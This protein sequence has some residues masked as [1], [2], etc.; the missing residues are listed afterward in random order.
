[1]NTTKPNHIALIMAG[2]QGTR[3][4]PMSSE[5]RP[6]QF[7]AITSAKSLILETFDRLAEIIPKESIYIVAD[8]RYAPQIAAALPRFKPENLIAEPAPRNTAPCLIYAN[9][10]LSR[11]YENA[12]VLVVP[13]DHHIP[14]TEVFARQMKDALEYADNRC[15]ITAG[16]KPGYAHTG[17]GYIEFDDAAGDSLG[18][19]RFHPVSA[20]HEKP[21]LEL[22]ESYVQGGRHYWNG[23]VFIYNIHHF[24]DFIRQYAADYFQHMRNLE[25]SWE[26]PEEVRTGFAQFKAE[27][28]DR[29]L[30]E[31]LKEARMLK[32]DFG[33][34]D[35]GSWSSIYELA[36]KDDQG[37]TI[38]G[39]GLTVKSRRSM[40]CN[41]TPVPVALVGLDGIC[42][43][44]T[45]EG[46]LVT[47]TDQAQD[48]KEVP[49]RL[50]G[51]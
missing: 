26:K 15:I 5:D 19:T 17:Y 49:G 42:V 38:T 1:M 2:G 16:I 32:A 29:V 47:R 36:P 44:V 7:L 14:D 28:I 24:R 43:I 12:N 30:M 23:G 34:N 18:L 3:F 22:A 10:F 11:R 9:I 39:E 46:I 51:R 33:W 40:I 37:N 8:G 4:W 27:A 35:V 41:E 48:V 50:A 20:F 13:A 6:K 31:K 25:S 21:G 45:R